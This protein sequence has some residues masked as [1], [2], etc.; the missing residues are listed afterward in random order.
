MGKIAEPLA[1]AWHIYMTSSNIR[2]CPS[3]AVLIPARILVGVSLFRSLHRQNKLPSQFLSSTLT[4]WKKTR[5]EII[6]IWCFAFDGIK[7]VDS[8]SI[9]QDTPWHRHCFSS[10]A[11]IVLASQCSDN[12]FR[13][14]SIVQQQKKCRL[15]RKSSCNTMT[16]RKQLC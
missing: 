2:L 16:I 12:L 1:A 11:S 15:F 5:I 8:V 7:P 4:E 9:L 14:D 10:Y 3:N 13:A 6:C